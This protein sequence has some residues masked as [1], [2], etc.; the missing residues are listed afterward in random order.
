MSY[1]PLCNDAVVPILRCDRL[2]KLIG[3]LDIGLI[4][5]EA[6]VAAPHIGHMINVPPLSENLADK[7][8]LD[9]GADLAAPEHTN[10]TLAS[11]L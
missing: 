8:E 1:L 6:N 5:G 2:R 10:P 7:M 3:T 4:K 11:S 9:Q